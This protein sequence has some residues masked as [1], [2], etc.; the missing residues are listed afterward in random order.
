MKL[1]V[2]SI[3]VLYAERG[4]RAY[5]GEAVSQ[6]EHALQTADLAE[7]AG[8]RPGLVAAAFLHDLGHLLSNE[9]GTPTL[10]SLDDRH[11]YVVLPALEGSFGID[12]LDPIRLHVDAKRYLCAQ[13]PGYAPALSS[14]SRRSLALQGGPLSPEEVQAFLSEPYAVDA[15][16]PRL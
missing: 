14:D 9:E 11:Q 4:H 1:A 10:S 7:R 3:A 2:A 13:R 12:V 6:L 15:C 8:A 5:A 16:G